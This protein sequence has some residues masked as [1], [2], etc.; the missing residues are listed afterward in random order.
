MDDTHIVYQAPNAPLRNTAVRTI[1]LCIAGQARTFNQTY[2]NIRGAM[3]EPIHNQTDVFM[4]IDAYHSNHSKLIHHDDS[5]LRSIAVQ[6]TNVV[7]LR[8][9]PTKPTRR[10]SRGWYAERSLVACLHDIRAEEAIWRGTSYSWVIRA[11]PDVV[12]DSSLPLFT[13]WPQW[14]SAPAPRTMFSGQIQASA[15]TEVVRSSGM[16]VKDESAVMTR[17]VA[18]AFFREWPP[19]LTGSCK[20][21]DDKRL[22][23]DM[24]K[25]EGNKGKHGSKLNSRAAPGWWGITPECA[26]G[27]VL[28]MQQVR[29][30]ILVGHNQRIVRTSSLSHVVYSRPEKQLTRFNVLKICNASHG[31]L[32]TY[33][34]SSVEPS[35]DDICSS[36]VGP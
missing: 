12:Y 9:L 33:A 17:P 5:T 32:H 11:R 31:Y 23:I 36:R 25:L 6:F 8:I 27:C 16:C 28:H 29:V 19:A 15:E 7:V 18:D 2:P 13:A 26:L 20:R 30:G 22:T 34:A 24:T 21:Y 35:D 3:L 14:R 4:A 1:A 10:D